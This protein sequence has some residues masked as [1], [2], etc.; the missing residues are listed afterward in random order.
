MAWLI[1]PM[2]WLLAESSGFLPTPIVLVALLGVLLR[3]ILRS[4]AD[5]ERTRNESRLDVNGLKTSHC[6][7]YR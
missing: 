3:R 1:P 2:G 7:S 5:G 4:D 6:D